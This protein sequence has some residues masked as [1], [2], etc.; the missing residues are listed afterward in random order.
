MPNEHLLPLR[1]TI[2]SPVT[3]LVAGPPGPAGEHAVYR[4][5][6]EDD[7]VLGELQFQK[8]PIGDNG[9]NGIQQEDLLKVV[10]HRLQSF[11]NGPLA[12]RENAIAK[13]HV[14][15]ALH[16]LNARTMDRRFRGV[17]G[18]NEE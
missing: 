13:T 7:T 1:N 10:V 2:Q 6:A 5:A 16:W 17:E 9:A 12:C 4:F 18:K 8:G 3:T 14:E 15:T 11:Q